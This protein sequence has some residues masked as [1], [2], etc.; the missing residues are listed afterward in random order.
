[1]SIEFGS[2]DTID[3]EGALH[4]SVRVSGILSSVALA[5]G[6]GIMLARMRLG[7]AGAGVQ[8]GAGGP[9]VVTPSTMGTNI[10][11]TGAMAA[12]LDITAQLNVS[13][14]MRAVLLVRR[15]L[16]PVKKALAEAIK[17][18][19]QSLPKTAHSTSR[20]FGKRRPNYKGKGRPFGVGKTLG[21]VSVPLT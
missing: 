21:D 4:A 9:S 1:M 14:P 16:K 18:E 2:L 11:I 17:P 10:G 15:A 5:E 7:G 19:F 20:E 13:I 6:E 8:A 3:V 12:S